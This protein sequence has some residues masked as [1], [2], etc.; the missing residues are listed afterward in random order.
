MLSWK[1]V[2]IILRTPGKYTKILLIDPKFKKTIF[3]IV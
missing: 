3:L 2:R 1:N